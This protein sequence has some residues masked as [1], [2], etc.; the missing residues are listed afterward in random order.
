[1]R[2]EEESYQRNAVVRYSRT[3][4]ALHWLIALVLFV[5][6]PLGWYLEEI[7]T[8]TPARSWYVNLHKSIGMTLGVAIVFRAGWR[9]LHPAPAL[10]EWLPRWQRIG[11]SASHVALYACML[12]MPL[13]GYL[14][15][16]FSKWGVK[17]FNAIDLPPWGVD[18][19]RIYAL[20][21]GVH[22]ATSYVLVALIV[23]HTV[24]ALRHAYR[25]DGIFQRM[26][27][28]HETAR[29]KAL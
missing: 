11:A 16:N 8:G 2:P 22:V 13:S 26:A 7:P 15:S 25:R 19:A 24:S 5:Q 21:N 4:I 27:A 12:I 28:G 3:A 17:Y 10:P 18:D 1:L 20:L 14:A 29:N 6:I 23:A 9:W